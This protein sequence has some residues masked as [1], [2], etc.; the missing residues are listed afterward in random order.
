MV[1]EI[2]IHKGGDLGNLF[3][4]KKEDKQNSFGV[5]NLYRGT[6]SYVAETST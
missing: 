3:W 4:I 2:L 1:G 6:R 5:L